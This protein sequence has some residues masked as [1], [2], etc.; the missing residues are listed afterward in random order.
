MAVGGVEVGFV[1]HLLDEYGK[2]RG[3]PWFGTSGL[4]VRPGV[5][6]D[7]CYR[8]GGDIPAGLL[9]ATALPRPVSEPLHTYAVMSPVSPTAPSLNAS[10]ATRGDSVSY[11]F[12]FGAIAICL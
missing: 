2:G 1:C 12:H 5:L 6:W 3:V 8:Q 9:R 7:L 10:G 11:I 4:K